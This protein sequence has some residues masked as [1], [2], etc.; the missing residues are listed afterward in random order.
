MRELKKII[1]EYCV[2][3]VENA[4]KFDEEFYPTINDLIGSWT[5]IQNFVMCANL[6]KTVT[7]GK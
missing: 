1:K 2:R 7:G 6:P 3:Y 4:K 5:N